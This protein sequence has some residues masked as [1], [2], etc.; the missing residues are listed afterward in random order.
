M[1][2]RAEYMKAEGSAQDRTKAH[3]DYYAQFVTPG[4]KDAV[5]RTFGL[6]RVVD[7]FKANRHFNDIPINE[8]DR[9]MACRDYSLVLK[10]AGD[11]RTAAGDICIAKEAA[12][13]VAEASLNDPAPQ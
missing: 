8:W 2:T 3:R 6:Q 4:L 1:I 5:V 12:R 9:L 10:K 11:Y 7:A 13:Q